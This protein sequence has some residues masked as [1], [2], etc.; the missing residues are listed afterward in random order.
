MAAADV[1]S[2]TDAA[3]GLRINDHHMVQTI[4][5]LIKVVP[6]VWQKDNLRKLLSIHEDDNLYLEN[7]VHGEGFSILGAYNYNKHCR[8]QYKITF[9]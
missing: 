8:S 7:Y 4:E 2:L 9:A 6:N 3:A 5:E 1:A